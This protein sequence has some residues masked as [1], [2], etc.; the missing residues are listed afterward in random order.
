MLE[1]GAMAGLESGLAEEDGVM[2]GPESGLAVK[3][4]VMVSGLTEE[5]GVMAG[6]GS[7]LA[8]EVVMLPARSFQ[9]LKGGSVKVAFCL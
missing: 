7:G 5:D 3:D 8:V 6:P 9:Q 2:A 4:G 1:A